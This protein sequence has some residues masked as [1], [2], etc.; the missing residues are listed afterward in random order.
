LVPS[1]LAS[2]IS[3]WPVAAILYT[4][5]AKDGM[6]QGPNLEHTRQLAEAG[7]VPVIASGR[8]G[9]IAHIE[10]LTHLPIWGVIVGRSLYEGTLD[11]AQAIRVA[12]ESN[13]S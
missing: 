13:V 1:A 9:N 4:D 11:L 8:V 2:Q 7:K 3:D 12:G 5:V 10:A 6:L